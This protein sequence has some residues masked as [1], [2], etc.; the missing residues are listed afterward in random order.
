MSDSCKPTLPT[1][2]VLPVCL[3]VP[4]VHPMTLVQPVLAIITVPTAVAYVDPTVLP[5]SLK[6][7]ARAAGTTD[8]ESFVSSY[9]QRDVRPASMILFVLAAKMGILEL[10]VV[11]ALQVTIQAACIL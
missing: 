2:P 3:D 8:T 6:T 9:V 10:C 1:L 5:V 7:T 11:P 4:Y